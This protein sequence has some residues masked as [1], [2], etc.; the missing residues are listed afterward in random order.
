MKE[1]DITNDELN[2]I[3]TLVKC[4]Y[5]HETAYQRINKYKKTLVECPAVYYP[6][7]NNT[8]GCGKQFLVSVK[9]VNIELQCDKIEKKLGERNEIL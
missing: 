9:E 1:K 5:C 7:V 3:V 2:N 8:I 6:D 4:P